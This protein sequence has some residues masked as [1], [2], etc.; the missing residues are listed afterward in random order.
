MTTSSTGSI[1][2]PDCTCGS[3]HEQS[4]FYT[5]DYP[6]SQVISGLQARIT[7]LE[8]QLKASQDARISRLLSPANTDLQRRLTRFSRYIDNQLSDHSGD[9][10][11]I[12]RII[13]I[14][15]ELGEATE[16]AI[17][18]IGANPRKIG[19][20]SVERI[21]IELLDVALTALGAHEHFCDNNGSTMADL[22]KHAEYVSRRAGLEIDPPDGV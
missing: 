3:K 1:Q 12:L 15:E 5:E 13:K 17:N 20:G 9:M 21:K 22:A 11:G 8:Q 2:N 19:R 18:R 16:Q 10:V 14:S 7:E 4:E 6:T